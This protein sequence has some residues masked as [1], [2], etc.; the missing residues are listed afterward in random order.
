MSVP[1]LSAERRGEQMPRRLRH[2]L[3]RAP[4]RRPGRVPRR[5][6]QDG[7]LRL[8]VLPGHGP[9]SLYPPD[10]TAE[11][12]FGP[13]RGGPYLDERT[14]RVSIHGDLHAENFGTYMDAN[15]RLI[16]NVNDF[17]KAYVALRLGPQ[18]IRRLRGPHRVR[19]GAQ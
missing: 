13:R 14:S 17:D 6:P 12:G 9:E 19:E 1:Q 8:R 3:R 5:V 18:A 2:R 16:F 4:G 15:G 10:L 7:G 11:I